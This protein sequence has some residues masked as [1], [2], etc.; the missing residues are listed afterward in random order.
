MSQGAHKYL[1]LHQRA[2]LCKRNGRRMYGAWKENKG[3]S[4]RH[5]L[6]ENELME[7]M[8][9]DPMKL[10]VTWLGWLYLEGKVRMCV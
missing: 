2:C 6:G 8:Q 5:Q 1:Y 10:L 9:K 7:E 3:K 4:P